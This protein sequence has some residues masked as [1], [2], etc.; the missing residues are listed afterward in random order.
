MRKY[1]FL[2]LVVVLALLQAGCEDEREPRD[3]PRVRTLPVTN[4]TEEGA[5]FSGEVYE[6]GDVTISEH[7]FAWG[8][9][10]PTVDY[11]NRVYLGTYEGTDRFSA[12]IPTTLTEGFTYQVAAFVKSGEYT[13]YGNKV[14]FRSLGSRGPVI[15]GFSPARVCCG[16]TLNI[17]GKNFSWVSTSN[18]VRFNEVQVVLCTPVTDTLLKIIVPFT[19]AESENTISVEISGNKTIY[20]D[21]RLIVDFPEIESFSPAGVHWGDT[22]EIFFSNLRNV[23]N[24]IFFIG[25]MQLLPIEPYDGHSVRIIVPSAADPDLLSISYSAG[26]NIFT[27]EDH[28][29]ILPPSITRIYPA[30]AFYPDTVTLYGFFNTDRQNTQVLFGTRPATIVSVTR[31][32]LQVI[33]P[34][35]LTESPVSIKYRYRQFEIT[36]PPVFSLSQPVITSIS[37]MSE[38]AG[39]I[40]TITGK[41]FINRYTT[42]KFN[43]IES[44]IISTTDT[45]IQCYAPGNYS[46]EVVITVTVC[47]SSTACGGPFNLT[48]PEII[49]FYPAHGS[50]GDT[51]TVTGRNLN[52]IYRFFIAM[53]PDHPDNGGYICDIISANSTTARVIIPSQEFTSGPVTAQAVRNWINSCLASE[54]IFQ[55]DAP[56]INSFS[57]VSGRTGTEVTVSGLNFSRVD[58]YNVV[59][60]NGIM[61]TVTSCSPNELKFLMPLLPEGNYGISLS[62]CGHTV[63]SGNDFAYSSPWKR[64]PDLPFRNNSFTMD[65][66]DEILVAAPEASQLVTLYK[67]SPGAGTFESAGQF[68]TSMYFFDRPVVKGDRAFMFAFNYNASRF[69][70]FDRN[71]RSF[72]T[73]TTPPGGLST[74]TSMMDGDSVLYAGGGLWTAHTGSYINEFWKYSPVTE[75][76]TRLNDLPFNCIRSNFF[77]VDGR[78]FAISTDKK[79]WEYFPVADTW[80]PVS[81]YP[82]PGAYSMLMVV[83]DGI[84]YLGHGAYGNNQIFAWNPALNS[85]EEFENELPYQRTHPLDF[86][87]EGKIY[88][89]GGDDGRIDF[90]KYDPANE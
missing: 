52:N 42:V 60:I 30:T 90:W 45:R 51:L 9:S 59:R 76:W 57:P 44:K 58:A 8:L 75:T 23:Y 22:V 25:N 67:F 14:E 26:G 64:L 35:S 5:L 2:L 33:V 80:S 15:T 32:S 77:T 78:N 53:D 84:V 62:V 24:P 74:H 10:T 66:G 17:T 69:L 34:G 55:V 27:W 28:F 65:F 86:E 54:E 47:G 41:N 71:T 39:G 13:V 85:W 88:I 49:S 83:S 12:E 56:V 43:D 79:I 1:C 87:Y 68:N 4:I 21:A 50:P 31:D 48:N 89:G 29:I 7:G 72:I 38:Y 37:P 20:S 73:E 81:V 3:Y 46:G 16:D 11:D 18:I 40:V 63:T 70:I 61:A 82:G 19:L 6:P 36:T